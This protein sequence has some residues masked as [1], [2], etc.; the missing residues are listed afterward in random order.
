MGG[1]NNNKNHTSS[2]IFAKL[3]KRRG[4]FCN[5]PP[6]LNGYADKDPSREGPLITPPAK[7]DRGLPYS[8]RQRRRGPVGSVHI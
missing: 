6:T 8:C 5:A 1:E 3:I 4:H 2:L 7:R